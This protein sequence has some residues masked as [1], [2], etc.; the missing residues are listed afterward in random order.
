[1]TFIRV[2]GVIAQDPALE[3]T[4][5]YIYTVARNLLY[6]HFRRLK[7]RG[8]PIVSDELIA[9]SV[10]SVRTDDPLLQREDA[11]KVADL[12]KKIKREPERLAVMYRFL[13]ELSYEE[14]AVKMGKK[15]SAVRQLVCRGIGRMR[16]DVPD[17][18]RRRGRP[19]VLSNLEY[20]RSKQREYSRRYYHK[21][22]KKL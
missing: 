19:S 10:D 2:L 17:Q 8:A 6:D 16:A 22:K 14:I 15:E 13:E 7:S 20:R 1:M 5:A 4:E 11:E 21:K 3:I 9:F 12:L 18:E